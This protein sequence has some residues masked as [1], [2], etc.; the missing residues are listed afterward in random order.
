MSRRDP[1]FDDKPCPCCPWQIRA[2]FATA[3]NLSKGSGSDVCMADL[4]RAVEAAQPLIDAH[5]A[6]TMH[7]H[8]TKR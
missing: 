8:G 4:A 3:F 1:P 2:L 5:F 6:D 7:S